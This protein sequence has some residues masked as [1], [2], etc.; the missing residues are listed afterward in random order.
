MCTWKSSA[1]SC[2]VFAEG[3]SGTAPLVVSIIGGPMKSGSCCCRS[4][5]SSFSCASISS[6]SSSDSFAIALYTNQSSSF[7]PN[8]SFL[9]SIPPRAASATSLIRSCIACPFRSVFVLR[10][11]SFSCFLS[12]KACRFV[13]ISVIHE[14]GFN[15]RRSSSSCFCLSRTA[16]SCSLFCLAFALPSPVLLTNFCFFF[17]FCCSGVNSSSGMSKSGYRTE[18]S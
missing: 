12:S 10:L 8:V 15:L 3:P 9:S 1:R 4:T 5:S 7:M 16:F 11:F 13:R 2:F 6:S 18:S 14:A 17:S